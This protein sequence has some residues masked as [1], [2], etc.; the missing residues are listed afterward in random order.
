MAYIA[1]LKY[2]LA[3]HYKYEAV[4]LRAAFY[5][6]ESET[7]KR[8]SFKWAEKAATRC[9]RAACAFR[10]PRSEPVLQICWSVLKLIGYYHETGFGT[11]VDVRKAYECYALC[12]EVYPDAA[13]KAGKYVS[14]NGGFLDNAIQALEKFA[15]CYHTPT[16]STIKPSDNPIATL[17][18]PRVELQYLL[19]KL[20]FRRNNCNTRMTDSSGGL[21]WYCSAANHG[22]VKAICHI[23]ER[24]AN[25]IP[26]AIAEAWKKRL[27]SSNHPVTLRVL[28]KQAI[29]H[30]RMLAVQRWLSAAFQRDVESQY[31]LGQYLLR[32]EYHPNRRIEG[33]IWLKRCVRTAIEKAAKK[34]GVLIS[35][36]FEYPSAKRFELKASKTLGSLVHESKS[37]EFVW[38]MVCWKFG[39]GLD[40]RGLNATADIVVGDKRG[41]YGKRYELVADWLLEQPTEDIEMWMEWRASYWTITDAIKSILPQP[42]LEELLPN[43]I[44]LPINEDG[45]PTTHQDKR[46]KVKK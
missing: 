33:V 25:L 7:C 38:R 13:Y 37:C 4:Q 28:G 32:D 5:N 12:A 43:F 39:C 42:I 20:L 27:E 34:R 22:H 2:A 29:K 45:S 16:K 30:D 17:E 8:R 24:C 6:A 35:S 46:R 18:C 36:G 26:D 11:A 40:M 19:A 10:K 23:I 14:R 44:S 41:L 21:Y 3:L 31:L 9:M 15:P 1:H